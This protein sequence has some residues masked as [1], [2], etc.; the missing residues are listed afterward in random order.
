MFDVFIRHVY[1]IDWLEKRIIFENRN[2][3]ECSKIKRE[4]HHFIEEGSNT[5]TCKWR[6]TVIMSRKHGVW[7]SLWL[8]LVI[9]LANFVIFCVFSEF[10]DLCNLCDFKDFNL[11]FHFNLVFMDL[12]KKGRNLP[13]T[14]WKSIFEA[15]L[16]TL[17]ALNGCLVDCC[18]S[19][20]CLIV[21]FRW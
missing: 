8:S 9:F 2:V 15:V 7:K 12:F 21:R 1:F 10:C 3:L 13:L 19:K 20:Y 18:F 4:F 11:V 17:S 6:N 16:V 14:F 5:N